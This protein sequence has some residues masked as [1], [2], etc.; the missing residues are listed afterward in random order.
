MFIYILLIIVILLF[1]LKKCYNKFSH[2]FWYTQPVNHKSNFKYSLFP[3]GIINH[4]MPGKTR[5]CNFKNVKVIEYN[6]IIKDD[7][8]GLVDFE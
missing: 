2:Q 1:L 7:L 5:W 8:K 3:P 4:G 6:N